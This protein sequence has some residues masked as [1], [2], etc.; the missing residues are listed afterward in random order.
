MLSLYFGWKSAQQ[1]KFTQ[2]ESIFQFSTHF[3]LFAQHAISPKPAVRCHYERN[4]HVEKQINVPDSS[5]NFP[6]FVY[7]IV[8]GPTFPIPL[9]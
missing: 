1:G 7:F 3:L 8:H 6:Y 9:N 5:S 4:F 2:E